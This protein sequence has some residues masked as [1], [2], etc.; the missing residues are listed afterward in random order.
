MRL[1]KAGK[2][3]LYLC[4]EICKHIQVQLFIIQVR[5]SLLEVMPIDVRGSFERLWSTLLVVA[6]ESHIYHD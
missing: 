2:S 6:S 5:L 3:R 1:R 4:P